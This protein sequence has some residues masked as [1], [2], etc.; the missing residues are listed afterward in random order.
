MANIDS[1]PEEMN[2]G[3]FFE[4]INYETKRAEKERK[5]LLSLGK[6]KRIAGSIFFD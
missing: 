3:R 4:H 5:L 6:S 2:S 1:D